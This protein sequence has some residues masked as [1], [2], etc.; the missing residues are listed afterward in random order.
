MKITKKIAAKVLEVVDAGLCSGKGV[1]I[2]GQMCVEA[3]VTFALGEEFSDEPSCVSDALRQF[4]I[5]LNDSNWSS[6]AARAKGLRRIATA[7]LGTKDTLDEVEFATR[8][9]MLTVKVVI[10]KA[11]RSAAEL[12]TE[13]HKTKLLE[14]ALLCENAEDIRAAYSAARSAASAAR[15]AAYSA[16]SAARSAV[17]SAASAAR[18]AADS[19][20]DS[21]DSAAS[22]ARSAAYSAADSADSAAYSAADSAAYSAA[23]SAARSAAYSAASAAVD[24]FLSDY[25]EQV[26]QILIDMKTPGSK[27]LS[28]CPLTN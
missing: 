24:Q 4:K 19:A 3:A 21:A 2:P 15:S 20:A 7:Q 14:M 26:V 28:I 1:P 22:A 12:Q 6:N 9:S 18:S 8:L 17:R 5:K 25:A 10:P 23:D 11:L 13:T 27:W 16:D